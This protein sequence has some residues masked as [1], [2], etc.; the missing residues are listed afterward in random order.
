MKKVRTF[1]E[2]RIAETDTPL[3]NF[4]SMDL[5]KQEEWKDLWSSIENINRSINDY[6]ELWKND[7]K[8]IRKRRALADLLKLLETSGLARHMWTPTEV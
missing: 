8:S 3:S 1:S 5:N 4:E 7:S 2:S 6:S